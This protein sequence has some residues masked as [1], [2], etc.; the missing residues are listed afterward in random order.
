MANEPLEIELKIE[1]SPQSVGRLLAAD[2]LGQTV[3]PAKLTHSVYYDTPARDLNRARAALRLRRVGR[4][5]IQTIKADGGSQGGLHRRIELEYPVMRGQL[6]L[7]RVPTDPAFDFML[8]PAV[9]SQLNALFETRFTRQIWM[10]TPHPGT[11]VEVALDRG[12]VTADGQHHPLCEVELELKQGD[13]TALFGLAH[14]VLATCGGRLG[15]IS[16]AE[17][18]FR[19]VDGAAAITPIK[20]RRPTLDAGLST[21]QAFLQ[22][23]RACQAQFEA[24][25][26]AYLEAGTTPDPEFIHQMRVALRRMR[27]TFSLFRKVAGCSVPEVLGAQ[28]KALANTLGAARNWDVFDTEVLITVDLSRSP[29]GVDALQSRV[30]RL[31]AAANRSARQALEDTA[32]QHLL[33]DLTAWQW[34]VASQTET[35][36]PLDAFAANTLNKRF[37]AVRKRA[38]GYDQASDEERHELRIA[39]KK[40]RYARDFLAPRLE[41]PDDLQTALEEVQEA[42]GRLNDLAT[43]QALLE[44]GFGAATPRQEA[45][46]ASFLQG[47]FA[48]ERPWVVERAA[49]ALTRLLRCR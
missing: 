20:F 18:G 30:A 15:N 1:L 49:R 23:I 12:R 43:T 48:H 44:E 21:R 19:L 4:H 28:I 37:R 13:A 26:A 17:R 45:M 40:L 31:R 10:V 2:W 36:Q 8:A 27:S 32:T 5:W 41:D 46:V 22:I 9:R 39:V 42:L 34:Q 35:S 11:L 38:Q 14:Q 33:L 29:P 3:G 7:T 16:K 24:N 47:W 25:L 6:D